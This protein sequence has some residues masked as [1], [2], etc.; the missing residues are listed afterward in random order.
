M[1]HN[2]HIYKII[3]DLFDKFNKIHMLCFLNNNLLIIKTKMYYSFLCYKSLN[4]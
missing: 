3:N 2:A 1:L 4:S